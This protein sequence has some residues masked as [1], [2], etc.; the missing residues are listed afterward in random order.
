MQK[1][2]DNCDEDNAETWRFLTALLQKIIPNWD[3]TFVSRRRK[4]FLGVLLSV[5]LKKK[6]N[7]LF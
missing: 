4:F 7:Y 3:I 5:F 1:K 6:S 2:T